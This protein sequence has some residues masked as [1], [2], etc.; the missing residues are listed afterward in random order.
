MSRANSASQGQSPIAIPSLNPGNSNGS[1]PNRAENASIV[2]PRPIVETV[3]SEDM[4]LSPRVIDAGAF[5]RYSEMLKSIITQA[6][7]QARTLE[8]YS[9]DAEA[10]IKR[11][12]S[13]SETINKRM[14]A[15]VRML[16]MIDERANRTEMLL[17]KIQTSL[18][19]SN[20][21]ATQI[22]ELI[23]KRLSES[24]RRIDKIA[25]DAEARVQ[26]AEEKARQ[27]TQ[28]NEE[29]ISTI[30]SL[31]QQIDARLSEI[32]SRV[33]STRNE[34]SSAIIELDERANEIR[35]QINTTLDQVVAKSQEAGANLALKIDEASNLTDARIAQL[36]RSIEPVLEAA[37]QAMRTLGMDPENPSFEDSPLARIENL[38][39]RG[40]AQTASLD[41]VYR[42]LEDLQSQAEGVKAVF[43]M[44][45]VDAAGE[46]DV[47][48]ARKDTL[49]G[50]MSEAAD[51][52]AKLGPDI[53]NK[54]EL[55]STQLTHLQIEQ[56]TL[57]QT[58]Q[59]SSQIAGDVSE[60][61]T[62]QS[63]QLQ[64]LL[65]GSLHKLSTRVEQ[66]GVWLG[67]LI[68]RAEELGATLPGA[69]RM[70]FGNQPIP[71]EPA[72]IEP[73]QST[74]QIQPSSDERPTRLDSTIDT[75]G[76]TAGKTTGKATSVTTSAITPEPVALGE[77]QI[78]K[79]GVV[80]STSRIV[81]PKPP[82]LPIDSF[83]F[84]GAE[85]VIEHNHEES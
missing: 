31:A 56:Q 57:R 8:D 1:L 55:A 59:A 6:N 5:T 15:G 36:N 52:I 72:H 30:N 16:K 81:S 48:E 68:Q 76:D 80:E 58:I 66:A 38:V 34:S 64:A 65:D 13:S 28:F 45:L 35:T 9:T 21:L 29:Q 77:N 83:S 41:R 19:D 33:E 4:F 69:G 12:E 10:M 11:C 24:Q 3:G 46:L 32:E 62:N 84:D 51:K 63:G 26:A 22:D 43:G 79:Q 14:Q 49:V 7:T 44:W 54:L 47:L 23:E 85:I 67:A 17:D 27:A 78:Q 2:E 42:Q 37:Q 61:M 39:E 25:A 60:Q 71:S 70:E 75:T 73:T 50:P 53:E 40:E 20:A 18:P 82:Q 74:H